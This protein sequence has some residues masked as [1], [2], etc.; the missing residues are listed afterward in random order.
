M[1]KGLQEHLWKLFG[2][3][4]AIHFLFQSL[5]IFVYRL[6]LVALSFP[7]H[8]YLYIIV[9]T[10]MQDLDKSS[11]Q[12]SRGEILFIMLARPEEW[13][14]PRL[15]ACRRQVRREIEENKVCQA[16][17]LNLDQVWRQALRFGKTV[18][19]RSLQRPLF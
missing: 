3:L 10:Q 12:R 5:F 2:L 16:L 19:T 11:H 8:P 14:D 7:R 13:S 17:I 18:L 15:E 4:F 1:E 6:L 9:L